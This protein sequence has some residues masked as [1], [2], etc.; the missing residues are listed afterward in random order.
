VATTARIVQYARLLEQL[1]PGFLTLVIFVETREDYR[2]RSLL[3]LVARLIE[4]FGL[5]GAAV[6]VGCP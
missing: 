4:I 2:A 1:D 5:A 6:I 3:D